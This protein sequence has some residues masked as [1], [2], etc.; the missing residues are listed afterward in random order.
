MTHSFHP[1]TTFFLPFICVCVCFFPFVINLIFMAFTVLAQTAPYLPQ[2]RGKGNGWCWFFSS[3]PPSV[4]H[5]G[6]IPLSS[7]TILILYYFHFTGLMA[8]PYPHITCRGN[9]TPSRPPCFLLSYPVCLLTSSF[10]FY[11]L[12]LSVL[13]LC[14]SL[15]SYFVFLTKQLHFPPSRW[16]AIYR[17]KNR[18][19]LPVSYTRLPNLLQSI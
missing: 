12:S 16:A 15:Y 3:S 17:D 10:H 7:E 11:S 6:L 9:F 5:F 19:W 13:F 1:H 8:S 4:I 18:S 14:L 2:S